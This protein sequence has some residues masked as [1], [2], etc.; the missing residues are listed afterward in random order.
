MG[1]YYF[2]ALTLVHNWWRGWFWCVNNFGSMTVFSKSFSTLRHRHI[3][4]C[5][6]QRVVHY[7]WM[8]SVWGPDDGEEGAL[9]F[10]LLLLFQAAGQ[11]LCLWVFLQWSSWLGDDNYYCY[12]LTI[13]SW[14]DQLDKTANYCRIQTF[15]SGNLL[16]QNIRYE[17]VDVLLMRRHKQSPSVIDDSHFTHTHNMPRYSR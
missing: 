1:D 13:G 16:H 12:H 3:H 11:P 5:V 2:T 8:F 6:M 17:R 7:T 15:N 14:N 4:W 10:F 9:L